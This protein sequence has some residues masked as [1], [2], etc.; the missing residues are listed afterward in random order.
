VDQHQQASDEQFVDLLLKYSPHLA[1]PKS[2]AWA[3][4]VA[5]LPP[6]NVLCGRNAQGLG[7]RFRCLK[8]AMES[9]SATLRKKLTPALE[10]KLQ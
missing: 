5:E 10:T 8:N 1:G 2:D 9:A 6:T 3:Y 7:S 4:V